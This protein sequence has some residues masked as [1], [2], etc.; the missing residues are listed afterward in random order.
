MKLSE[1][2]ILLRH[3]EGKNANADQKNGGSHG[4]EVRFDGITWKGLKVTGR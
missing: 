2:R 3:P 1:L 4:N